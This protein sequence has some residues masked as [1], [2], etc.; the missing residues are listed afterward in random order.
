MLFFFE[1]FKHKQNALIK[2]GEGGCSCDA[3]C[4]IDQLKLKAILHYGQVVIK[5]VH[6]LEELAGEDVILSHRL[7]KNTIGASEYILMTEPFYRLSGGVKDKEPVAHTETYDLGEVRAVVYYPDTHPLVASDTPRMTRL[8]G[9]LQG[10]RLF[11]RLFRRRLRG[12]RQTFSNI[13]S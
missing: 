12:P 9:F 2:A 5:Q 7:L 1:A 11:L 6:Q 13:P 3:C 10:P 4:N 8:S